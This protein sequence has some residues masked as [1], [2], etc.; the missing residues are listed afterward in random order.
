[1]DAIAS[2][3]PNW[4]SSAGDTAPVKQYRYPPLPSIGY[5]RL[6]SLH[7]ASTID[8]DLVVD[9]DPTPII[10]EGP[11]H[12][13]AV[14]YVW[15]TDQTPF[16]VYVGKGKTN[17]V[18][19]TRN[20]AVAL[21]NL[22]YPDRP[23][24]LWIDALCI[25]QSNDVEKEPQVAQM[26]TIYSF[27]VHVIAWLGPEQHDSTRALNFIA[28]MGTHVDF[29]FPAWLKHVGVPENKAYTPPAQKTNPDGTVPIT[30]DDTRSIYYLLCRGW[31]SRL[32]IR[33]EILALEEKAVVQ[34]GPCAVA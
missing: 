2:S 28:R 13:E 5:T 32:W 1:M 10:P 14:S 17:V 23:R 4:Q 19:V 27:A 3:K 12:Y 22:R 18:S 34:C 20:L 24:R 8:E 15:D 7:P 26:G 31:F 11:L 29:E 6:V 16:S 25:D 33:Q 21:S 30:A 9:L